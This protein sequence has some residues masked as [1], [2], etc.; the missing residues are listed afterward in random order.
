[1]PTPMSAPSALHMTGT[2]LQAAEPLDLAGLERQLVA[3]AWL[4]DDPGA[5]R[6]GVRD[7]MSALRAAT[8]DPVSSTAPVRRVG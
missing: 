5:Y 3:R 2:T 7:T 8:P 1:M 6:T 4:H